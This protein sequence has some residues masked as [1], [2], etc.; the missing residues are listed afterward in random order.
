MVHNGAASVSARSFG[1][2]KRAEKLRALT[3]YERAPL[4]NFAGV[5]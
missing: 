4:R 1:A 5:P 2:R 3:H